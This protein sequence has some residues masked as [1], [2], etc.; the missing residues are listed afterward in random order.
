MSLWYIE[1]CDHM[2]EKM[3]IYKCIKHVLMSEVGCSEMCIIL[4]I[5]LK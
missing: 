2:T 1:I 5:A 4:P 3:N